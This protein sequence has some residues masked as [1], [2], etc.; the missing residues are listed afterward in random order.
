MKHANVV[1][2][3]VDSKAIPIAY[4]IFFDLHFDRYTADM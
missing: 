4:E 2:I 3:R 1:P